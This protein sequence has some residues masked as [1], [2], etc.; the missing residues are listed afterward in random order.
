VSINDDTSHY[1]YILIHTIS[2]KPQ[3]T[4]KVNIHNQCSYLKLTKPRYFST[5]I[6]WNE[7]P[8]EELDASGIMSVSLESSLAEFE[9][10]LIYELRREYSKIGNQ[11]K[12]S[13]IRFFVAWKSECYKKLRVCIHLIESDEWFAWNE[14]KLKEYYQRYAS[15]LNTYTSPIRDT[16]LTHD[17]IVLMTKLELD[18]K[19]RDGVLNITISKGIE[20]NYT[21]GSVWINPKM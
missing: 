13:H 6:N 20:D 21:R 15:R 9:G 1:V 10:A 7:E 18:F 8:S 3:P 17:G 16:W 5:G 4:M 14:F 2:A 11:P 19:Q 12:P